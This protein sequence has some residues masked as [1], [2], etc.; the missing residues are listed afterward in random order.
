MQNAKALGWKI[1][2]QLL[3]AFFAFA[4]E[5]V[6]P[7]KAKDDKLVKLIHVDKCVDDIVTPCLLMIMSLK[8]W[9]S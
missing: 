2:F 3:Y 4:N 6:H 9:W 1:F 7:C 8:W 5:T